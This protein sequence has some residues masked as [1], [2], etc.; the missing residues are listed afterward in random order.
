MQSLQEME[1][2]NERVDKNRIVFLVSPHGMYPRS[3]VCTV[4]YVQSK[5]YTYFT[6]DTLHLCSI[7]NCKSKKYIQQ[8][9]K[10]T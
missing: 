1:D 9:K 5:T 3:I 2:E 8:L 6:D 7:T 4:S 10:Y